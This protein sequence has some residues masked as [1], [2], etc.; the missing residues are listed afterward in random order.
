M[1]VR[2][3]FSGAWTTVSELAV[4]AAAEGEHGRVSSARVQ[5]AARLRQPHAARWV[6]ASRLR[7]QLPWLL[8]P[9]RQQSPAGGC[10]RRHRTPLSTK[11]PSATPSKG[12]RAGQSFMSSRKGDTMSYDVVA[13]AILASEKSHSQ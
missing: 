9:G 7:R 11:A 13:W 10:A 4:L 8:R 1:G 12:E 3:G 2:E 5:V 6:V